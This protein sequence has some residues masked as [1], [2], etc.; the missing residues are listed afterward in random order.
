[1]GVCL[2]GPAGVGACASCCACLFLCRWVRGPGLRA[3]GGGARG[4]GRS[5]G[6]R[7]SGGAAGEEWRAEGEEEEEMRQACDT[8]PSGISCVRTLGAMAV[9]VVRMGIRNNWKRPIAR[10]DTS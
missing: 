9:V 7:D 4:W 1:M 3:R 5:G 10:T 6:N 2:G 8:G